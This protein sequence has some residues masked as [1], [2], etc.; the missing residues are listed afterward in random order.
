MMP[1]RNIV[2]V[3]EL[4]QKAGINPNNSVKSI[5]FSLKKAHFNT[6]KKNN[7]KTKCEVEPNHL[8]PNLCL[9]ILAGQI[10]RQVYVKDV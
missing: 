6:A 1:R 7:F 3:C 2:A 8:A 5:K 4:T 9:V 10:Q